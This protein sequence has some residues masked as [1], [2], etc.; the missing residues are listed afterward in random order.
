[1]TSLAPDF[2]G[3]GRDHPDGYRYFLPGSLK[4]AAQINLPPAIFKQL[5]EASLTLGRFASLIELIPNPELFIHAYTAKEATLSSRIEG[6]QTEIEDAFKEEAEIAPEKRDD[7]AEVAAYINAVHHAVRG[8]QALPLCNRLLKQ[9]HAKLLAQVRGKDKSPGDYRIKPN[10]I[11]G[12]SPNNAHFVPPS[13]EYVN[14]LMSD[15]EKF[16]HNDNLPLPELVKAALIHYQFETIHPFLDGNGRI[17]RM[18]IPLYLLHKKILSD[19]ILYI[20]AFFEARRSD[21]YDALDQAR[22][23]EIG[24]VNWIAFFLEAI[25][26][27]AQDG[28]DVTNKLLE[29]DTELRGSLIP[30]LGRRA[31]KGLQLINYLYQS[32]VVTAA[33]IQTTLQCSPQ[34]SQ[35]LLRAFVTLGVLQEATGN[36]RNRIFIFAKYIRLLAGDSKR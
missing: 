15:L 24:V 18:L 28:I 13:A 11:G 5:E 34:V 4:L 21:Y 35:S 36:K 30:Q 31:P 19:P 8:L 16:I 25:T 1:M 7:W 3:C 17:G 22:K 32:P 12:S 2:P 33:Q 20:S 14:D 9:T 10:W 6:T 29:Y 23:N 26:Q 27:S